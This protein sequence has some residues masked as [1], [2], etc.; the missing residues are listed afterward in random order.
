[1]NGLSVEPGERTAGGHVDLTG[2]ASVEIVGRGDAR[3]HLA[4]GVVDGKDG[5]RN[6]GPER[7][8]ALA[9]EFLQIALQRPHRW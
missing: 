1:M 9:R 5:N 4:G 7:A 8:G 2:A 6:V 3:E